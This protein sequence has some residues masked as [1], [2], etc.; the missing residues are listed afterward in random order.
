MSIAEPSTTA[1]A[2]P[3]TQQRINLIVQENIEIA[4]FT[5]VI[6]A[7]PDAEAS[8]F[9]V[10][11][12]DMILAEL[13]KLPHP[14]NRLY[15]WDIVETEVWRGSRISRNS[16]RLVRK[17]GGKMGEKIGR[18]IGILLISINIV[19]IDFERMHKNVEFV[20]QQVEQA[21]QSNGNDVELKDLNLV[22]QKLL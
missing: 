4:D 13:I 6:R 2:Q 22:T 10:T 11:L 19:T 17:R 15:D 7:L 3:T 12:K 8:E 21:Y 16:L 20:L 18:G 14:L 9:A 1:S 5:L